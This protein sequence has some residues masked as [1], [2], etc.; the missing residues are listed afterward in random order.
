MSQ[1]FFHSVFPL[2]HCQNSIGGI[3]R[4]P[5]FSGKFDP[6]NKISRVLVVFAIVSRPR[7]KEWNGPIPFQR[8]GYLTVLEGLLPEGGAPRG[9]NTTRGA[10]LTLP[11]H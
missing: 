7:S 10:A 9:D 5:Y 3:C 11:C 4:L 1:S 8:E 6:E 2:R